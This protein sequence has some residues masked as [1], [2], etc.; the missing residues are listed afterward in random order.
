MKNDPDLICD[1]WKQQF[2]DA[3]IK[4]YSHYIDRRI[5]IDPSR[6]K[7]DY[8]GKNWIMRMPE[9]EFLMEVRINENGFFVETTNEATA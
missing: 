9:R 4:P 7:R 2:T 8:L 1:Q 5:G 3:G 6:P